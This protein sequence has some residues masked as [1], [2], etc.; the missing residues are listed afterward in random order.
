MRAKLF[1]ASQ[2]V[3]NVLPD[4]KRIER[5]KADP[6]KPVHPVKLGKKRK[7]VKLV[8]GNLDAS[9]NDFPTAA[10]D[11]RTDFSQNGSSRL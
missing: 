10:I 5:A 3:C 9:Q 6:F 2:R 4:K 7:Q 1:D 11:K 8:G